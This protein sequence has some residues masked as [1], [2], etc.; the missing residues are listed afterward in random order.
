MPRS[1]NARLASS[2][3]SLL[4][5]GPVAGQPAT[6]ALGSP[7]AARPLPAPSEIGPAGPWRFGVGE[8]FEYVIG[9]GPVRAGRATLGVEGWKEIGGIAVYRVAMEVHARLPF[10]GV[11]DRWE[12]CVATRPLRTLSVARRVEEGDSRRNDRFRIDYEAGRLAAEAWDEESGAYLARTL[13]ESEAR[14]DGPVLDDIGFL[15]FLRTLPLEPGHTYRFE[16]HFLAR[17]NP[18]VFRVIGREK[19]R[20]PA[21]R[22]RT[23]VVEPVLP[24]MGILAPGTNARA[25]LTDDPRRLLV[26]LTTATR[27]GTAALHLERYEPGLP[28]HDQERVHSDAQEPVQ[29]R[30][31]PDRFEPQ[32]DPAEQEPGGHR[33]ERLRQGSAEVC[34]DRERR[35]DDVGHAVS[36]PLAEPEKDHPPEEHLPRP[37]VEPLDRRVAEETVR[38]HRRIQGVYGLHGR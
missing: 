27:F 35:L 24:G 33:G 16:S 2:V 23:L 5:A 30:H 18:V 7:G 1:A 15:Y 38:R 13:D 31:V 3:L 8:R 19:I 20:V 34:E 12:S 21:G 37:V 26:K 10:F 29:D 32:A 17:G 28:A 36:D 6:P 25:Y 14:V 4:C 9:V 22:F 11:D